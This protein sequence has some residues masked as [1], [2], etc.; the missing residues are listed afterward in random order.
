MSLFTQP[1][2]TSGID[3]ALVT[4]ANAVPIFPVMI[5]VFV[6]AMVW[7]GGTSNQKRR[8]G[9]AD[10]PF[11]TV[12]AGLTTTMLS[13]IFTLGGGLINL[14][15]LGIVVAITILSAVWFFLSSVRGEVN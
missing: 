8:T 11:W 4:T 3:D 2:L 9:N 14:T 13:L 7:M 15:T 12:L 6:F 10:Y 1:N 5:L